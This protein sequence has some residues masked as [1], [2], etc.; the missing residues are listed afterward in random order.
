MSAPDH[1]T[2]LSLG[3]GVQSSALYALAVEGTV[4]P[5]PDVAVFADT[6]QEPPWVYG[7]LVELERFGA[8]VLPITIVS[9][10]DLG[11]AVRKKIGALSGRFASVPFWVESEATPGRAAPGR[12]QCTR[13]FKIDVVHQEIRR[14]LGLG[15]RQQAPARGKTACT[16]IG[17]STDEASRAKDSRVPWVTN[18][19][20]LLELRLSRADC[21]AVLRACGLPVPE[22]SACVFCPYRQDVEWARWRE[23]HPEQFARA[24]AWDEAVRD[25]SRA[26]L[27]RPQ[28]VSRSLAPLASLPPLDVLQSEARGPQLNLFEA[29]CEGMCGV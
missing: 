18:R 11:E 20:P 5:R 26:G 7:Q 29:E 23:R 13:E 9:G 21:E 3:A 17:I 16:W 28:F 12:R 19:W 6:Q 4:G 25:A 15:P 14:R 1:V 27:R 10:G 24:V 22:K 2:V 8:G